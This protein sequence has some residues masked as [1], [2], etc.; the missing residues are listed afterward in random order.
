MDFIEI[1][2]CYKIYKNGVTALYDFDINIEKGE[3]E[4]SMPI[5]NEDKVNIG[6]VQTDYENLISTISNDLKEELSMKSIIE[7][8]V[9]VVENLKPKVEEDKVLESIEQ[10][11]EKAKTL[12]ESA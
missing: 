1:K 2:N 9:Q 8:L 6:T 7:T 4:N 5:G 10:V 12:K 11:L 3:E